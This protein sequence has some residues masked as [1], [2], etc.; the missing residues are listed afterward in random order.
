MRVADSSA[1]VFSGKAASPAGCG[2]IAD[3][4]AHGQMDCL[5]RRTYRAA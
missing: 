3:V 2:A 5:T 4:V 1:G